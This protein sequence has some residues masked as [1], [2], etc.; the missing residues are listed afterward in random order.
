LPALQA[1]L[2]LPAN[3]GFL[4]QIVLLTDGCLGNEDQLLASLRG[5][6]GDAR[7]YTVAIG[8]APN[9]HLA[10]KLAE[11]GRG[12]FKAITD[13]SEVQTQMGRLL[14]QISNPVLTD[15]HLTWQGLDVQDVLPRRLPDLYQ[16]QPL[17]LYG[18]LASGA[19]AGTLVLE[20]RAQQQ[21]FRRELVIDPARARYQAGI[22]TLW[23]RARVE[24]LMD[25]WRDASEGAPRDEARRAIV[26]LALRQRLVT[27]FTALVAVEERPA[28]D[29][30]TPEAVAVA[31]ELPAGW[32][33]GQANLATGNADLFLEALALGLLAA[34]VLLLAVHKFTGATA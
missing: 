13:G 26:D 12:T 23:A 15:L 29:Q 28:H 22:P 30:G 34:G 24:E 7:L 18:R 6:L 4:R 10:A 3:P 20:G 27:R 8:S 17:L 11:Y 1:V 31:T 19:A 9:H 16:G 2:T 33:L 21:V 32:Q 25:R 5:G 14:D